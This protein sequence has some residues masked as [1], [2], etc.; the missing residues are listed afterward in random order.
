M[1]PVRIV[2]I[3]ANLKRKVLPEVLSSH[4]PQRP[5]SVYFTHP[6]WPWLTLVRSQ[7]TLIKVCGAP[8]T[9]HRDFT[10]ALQDTWCQ[11]P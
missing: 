9:A 4:F 10:K 1:S 3:L 2:D 5:G 11:R 8:A 6:H 7:G